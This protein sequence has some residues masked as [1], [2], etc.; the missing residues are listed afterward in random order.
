MLLS[1][2][3]IV[4]RV[5][6]C[7]CACLQTATTTT[8]RRVNSEQ[9]PLSALPTTFPFARKSLNL[10]LLCSP[11]CTRALSFACGMLICSLVPF[12]P[13]RSCVQMLERVFSLLREKNP[14]LAVRK[15][16]V[17]PPPQLV[18]VGTRKTMW[19]NFAQICQ[20]SEQHTRSHTRTQQRRTSADREL[21]Q[22]V[23]ASQFYFRVSSAVFSVSSPSSSMHRQPEHAM[24]F[25]LA[26]M[27]TEGSIDGN[28]R[29]V[30]KGRYQPKQ[31]ESLLK[32]YIGQKRQRVK[33]AAVMGMG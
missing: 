11:A 4:S 22:S 3:C 14:N 25:F 33:A 18:R 19:A 7:C 17:M 24:S 9:C 10:Q 16:H 5:A 1:C 31:V 6:R 27:G 23:F 20:L 12:S 32:K 21:E 28:M 15:R 30:I 26:E 29:L 8:L 13:R 2:V